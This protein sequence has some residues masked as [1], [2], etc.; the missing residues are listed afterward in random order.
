MALTGKLDVRWGCPLSG[1]F[2]WSVATGEVTHYPWEL[3]LRPP[4]GLDCRAIRAG[5]F[6]DLPLWM[7]R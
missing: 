5:Q 1:L 3:L 2:R 4:P 6:P 7:A